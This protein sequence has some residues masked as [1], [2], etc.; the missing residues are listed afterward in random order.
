MDDLLPIVELYPEV[1]L[2]AIRRPF[3]FPRSRKLELVAVRKALDRLVQGET[4]TPMSPQEAVT[5][6]RGRTEAAKA[7]LAGREK[8]HTPHLTTWLN[9]RRYLSVTPQETPDNLEEAIS[10]LS[11]YPTITTVDVDA[12][13]PILKIID[14]HIEYWRA[15]HGAA[16]ASY[17][18][19][20]THR[21][22]E[23]VARW[24]RE[25]LQFVPNPL[26][27]FTERRYEQRDE[28]W[29]RTPKSGFES[30][31]SRLHLIA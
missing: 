31:R 2:D 10:V 12:H 28:L 6:L 13:M 5:Y 24:P 23:I 20:R 29:E 9:G 15:T 11:C 16:A 3:P 7:A 14:Q 21:Y 19:Q 17:L 22:A 26:R 30:E 1:A 4:G 25:D 18:R 8:R 27:W